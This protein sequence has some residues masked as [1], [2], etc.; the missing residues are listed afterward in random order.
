MDTWRQSSDWVQGTWWGS[1]WKD[2]R[3]RRG[4]K[5]HRKKNIVWLHYPLLPE[6]RPLAKECT[7]R[8][9][10]LQ[11]HMWQRI[12]LSDINGR[13]GLCPSKVW[14]PSTGG[15]WSSGRWESNLI[16]AKGLG[17]WIWDGVLV[18]G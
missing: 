3:S 16:Q 2:W 6:T 10:W 17:G 14:C 12:A 9:P 11:I 18:E 5:P 1:W 4:L 8:Y 7:G 15:C 13:G